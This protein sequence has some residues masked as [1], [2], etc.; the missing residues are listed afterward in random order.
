LAPQKHEVVR[1]Q[2]LHDG[3]GAQRRK[4][5]TVEVS[6]RGWVKMRVRVSVSV[7]VECERYDSEEARIEQ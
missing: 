2:H 6:V 1:R 4:G 3:V 5:D 7:T